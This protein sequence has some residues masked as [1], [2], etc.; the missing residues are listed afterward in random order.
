[1]YQDKFKNS[2]TF[3]VMFVPGENF[4]HAA[5]QRDPKLLS[6]GQKGNLII[7]GPTNLLSIVL[8]VAALRDQARLAERAEHI[9]VLGRQL[10]ENLSTL[11][12]N[13]HAMSSAIR[14]VIRNWNQLAGTL[15]GRWLSTARKFDELGVGKASV[16]VREIEL[17]EVDVRDVQKLG[18][19]GTGQ[20]ND[21]PQIA[22]E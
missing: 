13:A 20:E 17:L 3:V 8:N 22:A 7:V 15:D 21:P 10:Y 9:G 11:G 14:S 4:L 6:D 16:D 19:T 1:A 5:I 18:Q 2:A 12:K